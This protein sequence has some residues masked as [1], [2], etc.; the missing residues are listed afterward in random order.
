M[1]LPLS[2]DVPGSSKAANI[3]EEAKIVSAGAHRPVSEANSTARR[4]IARPTTKLF[5][6]SCT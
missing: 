3:G 4:F 5:A 2:D 1:A 6:K